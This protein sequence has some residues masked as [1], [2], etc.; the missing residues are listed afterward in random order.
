MV[1]LKNTFLF[2]VL[3]LPSLC[4]SNNYVSRVSYYSTPDGMGTPSGACGYGDYGKDVNS[5]DVCTASKRLYKNGAACGAC[6]QVRCKDKDLCS[7]E[8]TKVVVTDNGE[9]HGTDFILSSRGYAKMAKQPNMAQHL[10]AKGVVEVEYRRVSCKYGGGN[11]MVKVQE[12]SK[13]PNY[14]AVLVMNQGGAT[15]ILSVEVFEEETKEWISMRRA[16]GAVFDLS[17]PPSGELK[18]RFLTSAGAET[19]WVESDKAVIPAEWKAGITIE[20]DIQL[21]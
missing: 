9:G 4:Y 12:H 19:K 2:I 13:H 20:T 11:L 18:V 10:F 5:G 16:Y 3:L 17:N 14:L 1:F 15:D 21:S 8:G 7:D 6:Y